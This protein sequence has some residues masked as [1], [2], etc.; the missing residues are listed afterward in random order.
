LFHLQA[1]GIYLDVCLVSA[2]EAS[3]KAR[4][5]AVRPWRKIAGIVDKRRRQMVRL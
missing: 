2:L 4:A 3:V 5:I 1:S